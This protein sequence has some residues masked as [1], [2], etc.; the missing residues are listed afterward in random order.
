VTTNTSPAT[1][2]TLA[3]ELGLSVTTVSRALK[4]GPEVRPDTI[5]RVKK[6][7]DE[8]GYA[9]NLRGLKLKT[10]KSYAIC[11]ALSTW[12]ACEVGDAGSVA[13][14]QGIQSALEQTPYNLIVVNMAPGADTLSVVG[15]IVAQQLADGII[16]DQIQPQ[17]ARVKF[18]LEKKFPFATYG[19]TEL[20][21]PHAYFDVDEEVAAYD[22]TIMLVEK[23]H[24]RIALFNATKEYTFVQNRLR[25]Y[26]RALKD[27]GIKVCDEL[28]SFSNLDASGLRKLTTQMCMLQEPPTGFLSQSEVVTLAICAG[29]RDAGAEVGNGIDVISRD[30]TA[31]GAYLNP[32]ISSQYHSLQRGGEKLADFLL[33]SIDGEPVESLQELAEPTFIDRS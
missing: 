18:L 6:A 5:A 13:L 32:P 17:D 4:S 26:T 2:K 19:R 27:A 15:N 21:T 9:P 33:R 8:L 24:K 29:I 12:N 23:G 22:A 25:G 31:L 28:M 7:A 11:A 14:I 3:K 20:F 16:L 1:L 30:G 10:G